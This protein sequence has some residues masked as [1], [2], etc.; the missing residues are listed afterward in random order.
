MVAVKAAAMVAEQVEVA[1]E[2]KAEVR[3]KVASEVNAKA[4]AAMAMA[5][6]M[7]AEAKPWVGMEMWAVVNAVVQAVLTVAAGAKL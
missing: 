3:T 4:D 2:M 6:M 5:I 7:E 1:E